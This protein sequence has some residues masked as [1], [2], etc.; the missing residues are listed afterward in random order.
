[1]ERYIQPMR[2]SVSYT[3]LDVYK[4]QGQAGT[5]FDFQCDLPA[6]AFDFFYEVTGFTNSSYQVSN[7]IPGG[8]SDHTFAA[9]DDRQCIIIAGSNTGYSAIFVILDGDFRVD[10]Q[11]QN[12][13][14]CKGRAIV[15]SV[16]ALTAGGQAHHQGKHCLLYTS[17]CV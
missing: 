2:I 13:A 12:A 14:V 17:R 10:A 1:M 3:H 15:G 6:F 4:R 5:G 16:S 9:A 7:N 11:N 8:L